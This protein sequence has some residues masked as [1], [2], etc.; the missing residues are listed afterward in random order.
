[1]TMYAT[2][3][4]EGAKQFLEGIERNSKSSKASY[5]VAL[6]R[7]QNFLDTKNYTLKSIIKPLANEKINVYTL[8]NEF[9]THLLK[10]NGKLSAKSVKAYMAA[11]KSYLQN[12]EEDID[13]VPAKFKKKVKMPKI[14]RTKEEAIDA[15]DI[16]DILLHCNNRRLKPYLCMLGSGAMRTIEGCSSRWIDVHF[17]ENPTRVDIREEYT[18][19]KEGRYTFIS[20]EATKFLNEWKAWKYR[21][22]KFEK[23]DLI[24]PYDNEIKSVS[25]IYTTLW[26]EFNKILTVVNR[27]RRKDNSRRRKI[28]LNSFRRFAKTVASDQVSTDF[29]EWFLGHTDSSYWTKKAPELREIYKTKCMKYLTFLDYAVLELSLIHI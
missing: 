11:V 28:T 22:R 9:L 17:D 20:D 25:Y 29:S 6:S 5:A 18:K 23:D 15:A 16:R 10:N 24:F 7:F 21:E 13:I 2:M 4:M 3:E 1:M 19:T 26:R 8:L 14:Y 27:D 12:Q